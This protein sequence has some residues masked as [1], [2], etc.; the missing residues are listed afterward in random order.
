VA[1]Q[2][3]HL[4]APG[5]HCPESAA[6]QPGEEMLTVRRGRQPSDDAC[7]DTE[8][9]RRRRCGKLLDAGIRIGVCDTP[10]VHQVRDRQPHRHG[11]G[12]R[13][14]PAARAEPRIDTARGV[15][16]D[17][18][19]RTARAGRGEPPADLAEC[20]A[21]HCLARTRRKRA[22]QRETK[23]DH[24]QVRRHGDGPL[25]RHRIRPA[26]SR[27]GLRD[28]SRDR[29]Q[30]VLRPQRQQVVQPRRQAGDDP[31]IR[32]TASRQP[33]CE[34]LR[35]LDCRDEEADLDTGVRRNRQRLCEVRHVDSPRRRSAAPTFGIRGWLGRFGDDDVRRFGADGGSRDPAVALDPAL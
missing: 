4:C 31:L 7:R 8:R 14:D 24:R 11:H 16:G 17:G 30:G 18:Q 19:Q 33:G 12:K 35:D 32:D 13:G 25:P 10:T 15:L 9:T 1:R 20:T 5:Q 26:S 2:L 3:P 22:L 23:R 34:G 29:L 6:D 21:G 27:V 28:L